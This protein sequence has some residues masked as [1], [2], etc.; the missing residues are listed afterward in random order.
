MNKKHG[1]PATEGRKREKLKLLCDKLLK[2]KV[3]VV[4]EMGASQP[5][6]KSDRWDA[7]VRSDNSEARYKW[8]AQGW[9]LEDD[10]NRVVGFPNC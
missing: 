3:V 1:K 7:S 4:D 2:E 10:I 5:V 8:W 9:V 6:A